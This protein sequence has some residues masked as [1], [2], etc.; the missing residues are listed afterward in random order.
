M[1]RINVLIKTFIKESTMKAGI[2]VL[3]ALSLIIIS[4][5]KSDDSA[6]KPGLAEQTASEQPAP[7]SDSAVSTE[8]TVEPEESPAAAVTETTPEQ[9]QEAAAI[10]G[11]AVYRKSCASCHMTGA[12]GAPRTGDQAAWSPRISR[13]IDTLVQSAITGVPGTAMMPRGTCTTCS[14]DEI[15]AAVH[16][17]AG[18]IP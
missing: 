1:N 17:M 12:A 3:A 14:D 13:G 7:V 15:E 2:M 9:E 8:V 6:E 5:G 18:Q 11:E 16:Y 4:C 10:D